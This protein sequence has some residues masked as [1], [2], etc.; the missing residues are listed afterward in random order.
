MIVK[1][2][3]RALA[4]MPTSEHRLLWFNQRRVKMAHFIAATSEFR[5][6]CPVSRWQVERRASWQAR[7]KAWCRLC[8]AGV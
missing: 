3:A 6:Y 1:Y 8:H 2:V 5:H 4:E 7:S